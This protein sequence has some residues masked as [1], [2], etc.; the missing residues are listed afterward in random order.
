VDC[1]CCCL[2]WL[3]RSQQGYDTVEANRA[4]GLPDDSR[5]YES[6]PFIISDLHVRSIQLLTNNPRKIEILKELGIYHI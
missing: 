1:G 3:I 6:V 2:L 5:R 4:L